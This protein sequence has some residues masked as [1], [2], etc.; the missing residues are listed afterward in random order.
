MSLGTLQQTVSVQAQAALVESSQSTQGGSVRPTE[1]A[2]LPILNRTMAAMMTLIAGA[3]EVAATVS[4]H[5]A[6]SNWVSIG[7]GSGQNFQT[8]VDGTE[9]REDQCGGIMISYNLDSV[10]E[11]KTLTNGAAAEYGRGTGQVLV[12]TKSGT[13]DIHGTAFGY[14]RN[15]DLIRTDYFSDPAHGGLGQGPVSCTNNLAGRSV[16]RL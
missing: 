14:C 2:E 10:Q 8:L 15:Q 6:L 16:A 13:N 4:S 9:D 1:V 11:F 12:A 3:R 5:G 7:G